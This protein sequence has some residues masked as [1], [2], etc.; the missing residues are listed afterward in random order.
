MVYGIERVARAWQ[1]KRPTSATKRIGL[2]E[3]SLENGG[4]ISG[5][6]SHQKGVDVDVRLPRD[7]GKEAGSTYKQSVYSR[8]GTQTLV[9]LF[10]A[11]MNVTLVL[12]NDAK[13]SGV[14][15]WPNHDDHL[16]VRIK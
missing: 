5:H 4:P 2:G 6:V 7:D 16:H 12:F 15:P 1:T 3:T 13:V 11:E 8:A 10:R 14:Q 9:K